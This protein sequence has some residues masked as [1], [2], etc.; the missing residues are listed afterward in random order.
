MKKI[1]IATL[2]MCTSLFV[3]ACSNSTQ[4]TNTNDTAKNKITVEEAKDIALKHANLTKDKVQFIKTEESMDDGVEKYDIEFY[5]DKTE[6][7]YEINAQTGEVIEYDT[8]IEDYTIP[9]QSNG[10]TAKITEEKAK[11]I[12]L[13][14]ANLAKDKVSFIKSQLETDDGVQKYDIEFSYDNQEYNYEI[15]AD[16]GAIIEKEIDQMNS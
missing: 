12:A 15:N 10:N 14:D 16:T 3:M 4:K 13:K 6:Y 9:E 1:L 5:A 8:D 7:D 11:E 2:I